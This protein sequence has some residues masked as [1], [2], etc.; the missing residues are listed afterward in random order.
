MEAVT[1]T[2]AVDTVLPEASRSWMT[3][4]VG[5]ATPL[6][7]AAVGLVV[8]VSC[9]AAP[10]VVVIV[11]VLPVRALPSVPVTVA[12]VPVVPAGVKFTVAMPL[13]FVVDVAA[14]K[15]PPLLLD[16]VTTWPAVPT[17]TPF[18]SVS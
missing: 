6:W 14:E 1:L 17:E 5:K 18:A 16:H 10:A 9:E 3:G 11:A 12:T 7:G 4:C 13:L 15:L 8:I 2:F